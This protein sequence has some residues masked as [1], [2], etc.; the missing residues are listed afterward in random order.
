MKITAASAGAIRICR[1]HSAGSKISRR[2]TPP[3]CVV[4]S[5]SCK[6]IRDAASKFGVGS[7]TCISE[8]VA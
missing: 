3:G 1:S 7:A 5:A 6:R 2:Q 4:S 8:S